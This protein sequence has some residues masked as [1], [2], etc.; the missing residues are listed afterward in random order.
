MPKVSVLVPAHNRGHFIS[1]AVQSVLAQTFH[2][3]EVIIIDDGSRDDTAMRVMELAQADQRVRYLR[4]E[5]N[6]GA[7]AARNT[8]IRSAQGEYIA[9]LDSDDEWLPSK[10]ERQMTLFTRS[11]PELGVVYCGYRH[12]FEDGWGDQDR[13]VRVSHNPY[14]E[15]LTSYGLGPSSI[16][17]IRK[18]VLDRS[19]GCDER[20][21]A[22]QEWD[23]CIRLAR[24]GEFDYVPEPLSIYHMHSG[25]TMSKD[26]LRNA[27]GYLDV[28][29]SHGEEMLRLCGHLLLASH[30][31]TA[32]R[33]YLGVPDLD[34]ARACFRKAICT[35]LAYPK[36]WVY[37]AACSLGPQGYRRA[38]ALKRSAKS[39]LFPK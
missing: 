22:Y 29:N 38:A 13:L 21:R 17:V 14:V 36:A 37:L 33:L 1:R 34:A 23:L 7:Q 39:L 5:T 2:D 18:S 25:V 11:S 3:L 10:L 30:Y 32:G 12:V 6:R 16:L 28:V 26:I 24:Y 35:W 9:L 31:V 4:H 19:G 27:Q 8:G 15:L 20:V